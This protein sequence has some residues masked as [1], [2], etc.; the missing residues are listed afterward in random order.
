MPIDIPLRCRCDSVRG[1]AL[2][3]APDHG[4]HGIC[5]CDDCQAFFHY[6][7]RD[8]M[9]DAHGGSDIFQLTP[10][11]LRIDAG[12]EHIRCVRLSDKGMF[13]WFASCC[14]TPIANTMGAARLPFAGM[15]LCFVDP[16]VD[17][18]TRESA[19][20]KPIA[21]AFGRYA[22]GGAPPNVPAG[23]PIRWALR[24]VRKLA[25]GFVLGQHRPSP[26]FDEH[27]APV[28]QPTV[29]TPAQRSALT[30]A[31]TTRM[32]GKHAGL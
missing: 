15:L 23:V 21:F 10:A 24:T 32:D 30:P 20:G 8:E 27:G 3:L 22:R 14:R 25:R 19:F 9:L 2:A 11:Q 12:A 5:Y 26:F 18:A 29:L 1:M 31:T 4:T 16:D 13:R 17:Q 6:L 7:A 28:V